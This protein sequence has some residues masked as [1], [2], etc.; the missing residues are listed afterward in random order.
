VP[1][2]A[3]SELVE[4]RKQLG[5]LGFQSEAAFPLDGHL[6]AGPSEFE[7]ADHRERAENRLAADDGH[8]LDAPE[9]DLAD[10]LKERSFGRG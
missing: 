1:D 4:D 6:S 9:A 10:Y 7:M 5:E 2:R 3:H 8:R